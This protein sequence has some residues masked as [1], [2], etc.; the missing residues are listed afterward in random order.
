M[1]KQGLVSR[2]I[3]DFTIRPQK[4]DRLNSG[5]GMFEFERIKA[6]I[7]RFLSK[8]SLLLM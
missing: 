8:D 4:E 6:L 7:S 2:E 1:A 5:L 3:E